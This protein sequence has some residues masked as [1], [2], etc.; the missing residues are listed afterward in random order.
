MAGQA[1]DEVRGPAAES[2][3]VA[4]RTEDFRPARSAA[5][6]VAYGV[7]LD[8]VVSR[9]AVVENCMLQKVNGLHYITLQKFK[10]TYGT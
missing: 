4:S 3:T 7:D 10:R 1:A 8:D 9:R 6:A 2:D 5:S